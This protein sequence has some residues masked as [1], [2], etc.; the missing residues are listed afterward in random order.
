MVRIS[1]VR[2]NCVV[3]TYNIVVAVVAFGSNSSTS[4]CQNQYYVPIS[5]VYAAESIG[6]V[7]MVA[8]SSRL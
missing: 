5:T 6:I 7:R 8:K 4:I 2:S 1:I 3:C